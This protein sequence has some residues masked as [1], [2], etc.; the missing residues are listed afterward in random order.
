[1]KS[2]TCKPDKSQN[3]QKSTRSCKQLHKLHR[4]SGDAVISQKNKN[5][6]TVLQTTVF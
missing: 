2:I 1:M 4:G 5:K 3:Q 6:F